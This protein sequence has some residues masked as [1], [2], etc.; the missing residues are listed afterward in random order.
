[1]RTLTQHQTVFR[2][3]LV[4]SLASYF[5]GAA[6]AFGHHEIVMTWRIE[7]AIQQQAGPHERRMVV[8]H[9]G[10]LC[11]QLAAE[12]LETFVNSE[13]AIRR[14]AARVASEI[15]QRVTLANSGPA[16]QRAAPA[17]GAALEWVDS[18]CAVEGSESRAR[19]SVLAGS[20][21]PVQ[22]AHYPAQAVC[23]HVFR[24]VGE[25]DAEPLW[26]G[27]SPDFPVSLVAQRGMEKR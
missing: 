1:M 10:S 24:L 4:L 3:F 6:S 12:R 22:R 7:D 8:T 11:S 18:T 9:G 19:A 5:M 2:F 13:P 26:A 27:P 16:P 17:E 14:C 15:Q 20:Q 21:K 23:S 25:T